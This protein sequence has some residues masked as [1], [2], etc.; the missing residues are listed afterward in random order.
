MFAAVAARCDEVLCQV[1]ACVFVLRCGMFWAGQ[2]V[3]VLQRFNSDKP[4]LAE[5]TS[6]WD[7]VLQIKVSCSWL[8]STAVNVR[9]KKI[10]D[11]QQP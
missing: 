9:N 4:C 11:V 7:L 2:R 3:A 8:V 10:T 6:A 1:S 5:P